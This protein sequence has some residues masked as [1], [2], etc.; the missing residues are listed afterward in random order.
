MSLQFI[1]IAVCSVVALVGAVAAW[2][3]REKPLPPPRDDHRSWSINYMTDLKRWI[4]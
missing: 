2:V 4:R 1:G 3:E